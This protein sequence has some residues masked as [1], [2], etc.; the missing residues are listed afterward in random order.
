MS[1]ASA[2]LTAVD[3]GQETHSSPT[4]VDIVLAADP[5]DDAELPDDGEGETPDDDAGT[6]TDTFTREYVTNLRREAASHRA[7]AT[8]AEERADSLARSLWTE[9]VAGLR[10]LADPADLP[11]D[12]DA[13]DD[14]SAIRNKAEE[15]LAA[16]PH[17]RSRRIASRAGQ[18]EGNAAASVSLSEIL[19]AG[20]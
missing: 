20:A 10:L 7:R 16:R 17:L 9:R 19:R 18:G 15:L 5:A 3:G 4:D 14:V 6:E 2:S 11:Y 12:G 1:D 13:L 8:A